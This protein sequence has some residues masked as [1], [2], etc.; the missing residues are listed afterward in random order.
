[1]NMLDIYVI[2]SIIISVIRK[3]KQKKK[4]IESYEK[5]LVL[6]AFQNLVLM[7]N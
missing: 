7:R 6:Q 2:P 1:M 3:I 4:E 5:R